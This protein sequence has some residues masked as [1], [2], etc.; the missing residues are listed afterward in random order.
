MSTTTG[1]PTFSSFYGFGRP[2]VIREGRETGILLVLQDHLL[3]DLFG[4]WPA[5]PGGFAPGLVV[6]GAPVDVPPAAIF[7]LG[8]AGIASAEDCWSFRF[9]LGVSDAGD[10]Y[11]GDVTVT[12][13]VGDHEEATLVSTA[14]DRDPESTGGGV[15]FCYDDRRPGNF[16]NVGFRVSTEPVEGFRTIEIDRF[17]DD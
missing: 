13:L 17:D 5:E 1:R 9:D 7:G 16:D 12:L 10:L 8:Y 6:A 15:Q 2:T 11:P 14:A 4:D 3:R